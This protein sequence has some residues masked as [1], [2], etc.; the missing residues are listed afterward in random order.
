MYPIMHGETSAGS[1]TDA[2][3]REFERTRQIALPAAYRNFLKATDGGVPDRRTFPIAGMKDNPF[4]G[5]QC[6]FGLNSPTEV[7]TLVWNYDLYAGGFP[8][9]I[10]PIAGNGGG[11]YVCLDLR[12][13]QDRV[14]FWNF[15]HYWGTGQWRD[16]DLYHVANT[17]DEFLASLKPSPY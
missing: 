3:I 2:Q 7:N 4:G 15:R 12:D 10:V 13:G 14:V 16:T 11:D 9:G 1:T 6:F 5:I 8:R 17:F